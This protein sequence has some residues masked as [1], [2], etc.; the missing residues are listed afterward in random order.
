MHI[1]SYIQG[2]TVD[3]A[4]LHFRNPRWYDKPERGFDYVIAKEEHIL[5]DYRQMGVQPYAVLQEREERQAPEKEVNKITTSV[6]FD[7]IENFI[8]NEEGEKIVLDTLKNTEE[9]S[10]EEVITIEEDSKIVEELSW[11]EMRK[12]AKE[13]SGEVIRS[14]EQAQEILNRHG[15]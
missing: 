12:L 8:G 5:D 4:H 15:Y 7:V 9:Q 14:K 2:I 6:D 3:G 13:L 1:I 10:P 11:N